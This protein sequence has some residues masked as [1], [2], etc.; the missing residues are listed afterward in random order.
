MARDDE[1]QYTP[2]RPE[3]DHS[4]LLNFTQHYLRLG[5][6]F[7]STLIAGLVLVMLGALI[8]ASI[9]STA[10]SSMKNRLGLKFRLGD[11]FEVPQIAIPVQSSLDAHHFVKGPA[12]NTFRGELK[13]PRFLDCPG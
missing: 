7:S 12:T 4:S 9:E 1:A 3:D 2:L 11:D 10:V 6:R 13:E 5:K 8:G